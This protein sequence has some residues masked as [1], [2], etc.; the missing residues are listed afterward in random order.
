[1]IDK[2]YGVINAPNEAIAVFSVAGACLSKIIKI[3]RAKNPVEIYENFD[4]G[5][6]TITHNDKTDENILTITKLQEISMSRSLVSRLKV[7]ILSHSCVCENKKQVFGSNQKSDSKHNHEG[8]SELDGN[9]FLQKN[10]IN[11]STVSAVE[12]LKSIVE[13]FDDQMLDIIV[14]F[15]M[16][17]IVTNL[18]KDLSITPNSLVLV[19][20][21]YGLLTKA[22]AKKP[23]LSRL[24]LK[25]T[26][27][28]ELSLVLYKKLIVCLEKNSNTRFSL[29]ALE[30]HGINQQELDQQSQ[31]LD[32]GHLVDCASSI[33]ALFTKFFE[34]ENSDE[35]I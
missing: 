27:L 30:D 16:F 33:C 12:L 19:I 11:D 6:V 22:L 23:C 10:M 5:L 7:V 4:D 18:L 1:M 34:N 17:E 3:C 26:N 21:L 20:N 32:K 9:E 24:L 28:V 29:A 31:K 8:S 13:G 35:I 25:C 14:E 15:E 2:I